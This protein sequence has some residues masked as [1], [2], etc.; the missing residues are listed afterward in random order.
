[1]E[2]RQCSWQ[3]PLIDSKD[4]P[5]R[6]D[7]CSDTLGFIALWFHA[8]IMPKDINIVMKTRCLKFELMGWTIEDL[9]FV[10]TCLTY[11]VQIG[12]KLQGSRLRNQNMPFEFVTFDWLS[13]DRILIEICPLIDQASALWLIKL[14]L[15]GSQNLAKCL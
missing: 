10:I 3:G 15:S 1:M 12:Y 9:D 11:V 8:L 5:W 14:R 4:L 13:R 7:Y 2:D 6:F